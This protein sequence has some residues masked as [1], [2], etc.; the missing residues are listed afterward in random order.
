MKDT[1]SLQHI[2]TF[3]SPLG[4]EHEAIT[5]ILGTNEH[6]NRDHLPFQITM[7]IHTFIQYAKQAD[8][9]FY[10][11]DG[12]FAVK[13]GTNRLKCLTTSDMI[14]FFQNL[15]RLGGYHIVDNDPNPFCSTCASEVLLAR[16]ECSPPNLVHH[17]PHHQQTPLHRPRIRFMP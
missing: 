2:C 9:D 13:C 7:E 11:S 8:E 15:Y 1:G 6:G 16:I 5:D 4:F 3:V 17:R 12:K 14:L 10:P